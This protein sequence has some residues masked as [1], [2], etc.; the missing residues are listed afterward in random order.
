MMVKKEVILVVSVIFLL[1]AI[2]V[3]C[4][5]DDNSFNYLYLSNSDNIT[6]EGSNYSA[7]LNKSL[8]FTRSE[9]HTS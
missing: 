3:V 4:G 2:S 8:L 6:R 5:A 1:A 9:E 7:L